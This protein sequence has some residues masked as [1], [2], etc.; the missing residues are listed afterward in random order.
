M[1]APTRWVTDNPDDHAHRYVARFRALA[2]DGADLGGEARLVDAM[3][4]RGA[5]VLDAGCGQG[6]VGAAL[7]AAGHRVVGVDA[8]RTLIEAAGEDNPGP[9]YVVADLSELDLWATGLVEAFDGAV[10]AGN[11]MP[12]VAPGSEV[13]VLARIHEHLRDDGFLL[14]GF[15]LGRGYVLDDFDTHARDAGFVVEQRFATWDLRPWSPGA[16]A[17]FAVT[18]LRRPL[19]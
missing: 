7:H 5:H 18:V 10:M 8:D 9:H 4:P 13:D 12:Y 11:V 16:G 2:A 17:D 14:V 1:A 6:R 19:P 15:G 3:L